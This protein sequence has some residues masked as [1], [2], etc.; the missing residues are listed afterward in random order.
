MNLSALF[1]ARAYCEAALR[2]YQHYQ[3]RAAKDEARTQ[4]L[5]DDIDQELAKLAQ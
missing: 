1:R 4:T 3:G 5:L 2:D